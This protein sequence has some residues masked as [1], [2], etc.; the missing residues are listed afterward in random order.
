M[1]EARAKER[2]GRI[3]ARRPLDEIETLETLT[4]AVKVVPRK[5]L[6]V[7]PVSPYL[8]LDGTTRVG[9]RCV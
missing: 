4:A 8:L 3:T 7:K 1:L 6:K 2:V 5:A 9:M